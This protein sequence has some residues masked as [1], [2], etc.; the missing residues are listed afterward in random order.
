MEELQILIE[1]LKK[2]FKFFFLKVEW[3]DTW[4]MK[5]NT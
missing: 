4:N 5:N 3:L 1:V 2:K